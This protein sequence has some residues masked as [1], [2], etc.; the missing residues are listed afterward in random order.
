MEIKID[1][2]DLLDRFLK[3]IRSEEAKQVASRQMNKEM[4]LESQ[5]HFGESGKQLVTPKAND[6]EAVKRFVQATTSELQAIRLSR[7]KKVKS[8]FWLSWLTIGAAVALVFIGLSMA[9]W[10]QQDKQLAI[11]T[12]VCAL[13]PGFVGSM[14][15]KFYEKEN[16][17]LKIIEAELTKI[18][19]MESYFELAS[20]IGNSTVLDEA[21]K[22]LIAQMEI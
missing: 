7:E 15:F 17:D 18:G 11:I 10:Q 21:Y 22:K 9:F 19:K 14:L 5:T 3:S 2:Q 16:N 13:I 20:R 1:N 8:A 12:S 4:L 6:I